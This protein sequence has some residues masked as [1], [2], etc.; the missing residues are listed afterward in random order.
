M[1]KRHWQKEFFGEDKKILIIPFTDKETEKDKILFANCQKLFQIMGLSSF[2]VKARLS[3]NKDDAKSCS[4]LFASDTFKLYGCNFLLELIK[5][6]LDHIGCE[7][8][9]MRYRTSQCK[10]AC[11]DSVDIFLTEFIQKKEKIGR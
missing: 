7:T 8:G 10:K 2:E 1:D 11:Q 4:L 9:F 6:I 5:S 3:R